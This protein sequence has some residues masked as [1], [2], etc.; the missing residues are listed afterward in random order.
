MK[1]VLYGHGGSQN[2]GNEAIARGLSELFPDAEY[3]IYT[4]SRDIDI[5]YGLNQIA[6]LCHHMDMRKKT[7]W[8]KIL[9]L[10]N[11]EFE[12][13]LLFKSFLKSI[14]KDVVYCLEAG[15][16][17]NEPKDVRDWYIYLNK[18]INQKGAK[19]VMLG[20]SITEDIINKEEVLDD[21]QRYSVVIARETLTYNLLL[22]AGIKAELAPCPAFAM[23]A[24]ACT[25]PIAFENDK[26][27]IGFNVG[28][29]AQGNEVYYDLLMKNY[30][31]AIQYVLNSTD[32]NIL[33]VPHVN[34]G[35]SLA[36]RRSLEKL[37]AK[38]SYSDRI[39]LLSEKNAP[40]VKYILSKLK[41]FVGL[42][43]HTQIPAIAELVPTIIAGYK[44]K[45]LGISTDVYGE[46]SPLLAHV[47]ALDNQNII[48]E[49][50]EYVLE[51]YI[52]IK[53]YMEKNIPIYL[54][55]LSKIRTLLYNLVND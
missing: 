36:D 39:F 9:I 40:K 21:L 20:C 47:Q 30:E 17:Y 25:L 31:N 44:H 29:L 49:K 12:Y 28:F 13:K 8:Q 5:K 33:L 38:F 19:T 6:S 1:L 43:T 7:L 42:R 14:R 26:Q 27:V 15:D 34:W 10:I 11:K 22:K 41:V 16:Q 3:Q 23:K 52:D 2:H 46:K 55:N 54:Q 48:K 24:E 51:N 53:S 50:L 18:K 32:Y 35:Y 37:Y 4:M 45:S